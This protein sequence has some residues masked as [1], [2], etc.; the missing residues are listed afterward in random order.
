MALWTRRRKD[1]KREIYIKHDTKAIADYAYDNA[2]GVW[3]HAR[4]A[5]LPQGLETIGC[6][7]FQ[8]CRALREIVIPE[9][10]THIGEGAFR[11]CWRLRRIVLPQ[12][13][14]SIGKDAFAG[15]AWLRMRPWDK[16]IVGNGILLRCRMGTGRRTLVIP[17]GVR[18]I[19]SGV[20]A[21][22]RHIR[23]V[24]FKGGTL[25]IGDGAFAGC[26]ELTDVTL[27][28]SLRE[29]GA[30]AFEN[31]TS[32]RDIS[33]GHITHIGDQAFRGCTGLHALTLPATVRTIGA[34]A[35][36]HCTRIASA[37]FPEEMDTIGAGAFLHC[38]K[39]ETVQLPARLGQMGEHAFQWCG[40]RALE[41]PGWPTIA[42]EA[43]A[44]C[45]HLEDLRLAEGIETIGEKA[46][47]GCALVTRLDLPTGLRTIGHG[48]FQYCAAL[49]FL[50]AARG[51][52]TI[53][54]AAFR[55]C[56]YLAKVTLPE[57]LRRIEPYAFS[58]CESLEDI[59]VPSTVA[60]IEECAL[61][62]T[63]WLKALDAPLTVVGEGLLIKVKAKGM[64]LR[65]P[66]TVR[67][68]CK[69]AF[70]EKEAPA[71]LTMGTNVQMIADQYIPTL[72]LILE[73]GGY[74]ARI[75]LQ[76]M[77]NTYLR[78]IRCTADDRFVRDFLVE[79]N[80]PK[81][82]LIFLKIRDP[83]IRFPLGVMMHAVEPDDRIYATFIRKNYR[84]AGRWIVRAGEA[85]MLRR[86]LDEAPPSREDL[87][88]LMDTATAAQSAA[89]S[90]LLLE[91]KRAQ[92]GIEDAARPTSTMRL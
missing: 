10:V 25:C 84:D 3:D 39:L 14:V 19:G 78:H 16:L 27:P 32:L 37:V 86:Y 76:T 89:C 21:G 64:R 66:G 9:G 57:G 88:M 70:D 28:D 41:V 30:R 77:R 63:P 36:S 20:F 40:L 24:V 18:G 61:T 17:D 43:F 54:S 62:E 87:Q 49:V 44:N 65:I 53:G 69:G 81:R 38:D 26:T 2:S 35:F 50:T 6:C 12:S 11:G 72:E 90:A 67:C 92:F 1:L 55:G 42:A 4:T 73:R 85:G 56:R 80:A 5:A 23:R 71:S 83:E 48:A 60:A 31:C 75:P 52:E 59:N 13:L 45:T 91:W 74:Q 34:E 15:T 46:F 68:I 7:A 47:Y 51:L 29:I 22:Q 79:Q 58:Q 33:G 82:A 8:N